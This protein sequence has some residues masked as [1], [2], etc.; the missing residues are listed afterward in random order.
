[1]MNE[2][3][4]L[5][6][7]EELLAA[8]VGWLTYRWMSQDIASLYWCLFAADVVATVFV[9]I[10][11]LVF[12]NVSVYDPYW[13]VLP[14]VMMTALAVDAGACNWAV[15][16]LLLAVWVWGIRLTANWAYT[17]RNLDSEDWRYTKYRTEQKDFIF[18]IINFFG[19]N[20]VPTVV[21]FLAMMPGLNL[22]TEPCEV[23]VL[24]VLALLCV[25]PRRRFSWWLIRRNTAFQ[26]FTR[27]KSAR[28]ACGSTAAIPTV[29]VKS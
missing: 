7:K 29:L 25:S 28:S 19:L 26:R 17:F 23:N 18:Q 3:F 12:K 27:V 8:L 24:L 13:S 1:M 5:A 10:F 22:I 4:E 9:W 20:M 15:C 16:L 6:A 21:V 11:G 14:P 2:N